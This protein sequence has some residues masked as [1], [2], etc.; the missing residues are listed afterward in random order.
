MGA[1]A[2]YKVIPF[3]ILFASNFRLP[4]NGFCIW[5]GI[6]G[7]WIFIT[8]FQKISTA[9]AIRALAEMKLLLMAM[10]LLPFLCI[11]LIITTAVDYR[12]F[13]RFGNKLSSLLFS[14]VFT[15]IVT[16]TTLKHVNQTSQQTHHLIKPINSANSNF[17]QR[18]LLSIWGQL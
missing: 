5:N 9:L 17:W 12:Y 7:A 8:D 2:P 16:L 1:G 3:G 10:L 6:R 18:H 4:L 11:S 14:V 15:Q 13:L